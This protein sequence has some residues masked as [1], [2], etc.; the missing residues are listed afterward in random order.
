MQID[1]TNQHCEQLVNLWVRSNEPPK[2]RFLKTVHSALVQTARGKTSRKTISIFLA[3]RG[4]LIYPG[5][6]P[7]GSIFV[8]KHPHIVENDH[9]TDI[10]SE[11]FRF[12]QRDTEKVAWF[13]LTSPEVIIKRNTNICAMGFNRKKISGSLILHKI[14]YGGTIVPNTKHKASQTKY[15]GT[16]KERL[17]TRDWKLKYKETNNEHGRNKDFK[18][19]LRKGIYTWVKGNNETSIRALIYIFDLKKFE[20]YVQKFVKGSNTKQNGWMYH[21]PRQ[22]NKRRRR[23]TKHHNESIQDTDFILYSRDMSTAN[24]K[25]IIKQSKF[26][27]LAREFQIPPITRDT[28]NIS[29]IK[30]LQKY[31]ESWRGGGIRR[32][33]YPKVK[34]EFGYSRGDSDDFYDSEFEEYCGDYSIDGPWDDDM[35]PFRERQIVQMGGYFGNNKSEYYGPHYGI[36][37]NKDS[38]LYPDEGMKHFLKDFSM[39]E[40]RTILDWVTMFP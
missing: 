23:S 8:F 18:L 10:I 30:V 9:I 26:L 28:S 36:F 24:P 22:A 25:Q 4:L 39:E 19:P 32:K 35:S 34:D 1:K 5:Q 38:L 21:R 40:K 20:K 14:K 2:A 16:L 29:L 7:E 11:H 17:H 37:S 13:I 31:K 3:A 12:K 33:T 27:G 15:G 6:A